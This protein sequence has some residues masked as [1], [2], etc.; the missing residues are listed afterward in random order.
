MPAGVFLTENPS[1]SRCFFHNFLQKVEKNTTKV[2]DLHF[3][4]YYYKYDHGLK[5]PHNLY[6]VPKMGHLEIEE[7]HDCEEI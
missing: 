6:G 1:E 2:V 7:Q 5:C 3:V 4:M